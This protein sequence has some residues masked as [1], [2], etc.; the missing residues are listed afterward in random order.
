M[1][2]DISAYTKRKVKKEYKMKKHKYLRIAL[3]LTL[4]PFCLSACDNQTESIEPSE[5]ENVKSAEPSPTEAPLSKVY[6]TTDISAEGLVA[7]YEALGWTAEGDVAV[8]L[9]TGEPPAS[10]YLRPDLIKDLIQ[11]VEGT[12][13]ECNTIAGT[14][15][16]ET[17]MHM[18]VAKDH[19][20]TDI[21]DVDIM[22]ADGSMVL[23]VAGGI[24]LTENYVGS[25]VGNYD[26]FIVL[27]H[28]KGHSMAGFG[29][30]IKNLS[31]G[32]ASSEGKYWIHSAGTSKTDWVAV[33]DHFLE[34]MAEA[35]KSVS[36]YL[37]NGKNIVYINVMNRLS[38]DCDCH[39]HPAEPLI[40]DI[41]ILASTDPV[42]LDQACVD[43]I[44]LQEE[45]DAALLCY[46][47][48]Q[49]NGQHLLEYGEQIGL[50]S[51]TYEVISID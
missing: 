14:S 12:I 4:L 13:V 34:S 35:G 17:L 3:V 1:H 49:Q 45:G 47:I 9:H 31:I 44:Y 26:S 50:G 48:D 37:S 51:R 27:S 21:A 40:A 33:N 38:V 8:K 46:M 25:H 16:A 2:E 20:Y 30:A 7:I 18:Q 42:A 22:D 28:F 39:G 29:G 15:R 41:G 10:N 11:L 23:P 36:D 5:S 6:M 43:L 32:I 24:H 19:G